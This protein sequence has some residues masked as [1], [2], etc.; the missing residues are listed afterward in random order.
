MTEQRLP[1]P[2]RFV[3]DALVQLFQSRIEQLISDLGR[4][5]TLTLPP[6]RLDCPNCGW[7]FVQ[8]RSNNIHTPNASGAGLNKSFP[9]GQ[10]CPVCNGAG[11]LDFS[12]Q[13][14]HKALI[15]FGPA[16]EEFNYELWGLTPADVIRTKTKLVTQPDFDLSQFAIIDGFECEK[17]TIPRKT[18]LRDLAFLVSYWKRRNS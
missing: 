2:G 4:D 11:K 6:L 16:P 15:G 3:N 9:N 8:Q 13:I 10:R 14:I 5:I 7:D 12:R 18:G 17:I 1:P